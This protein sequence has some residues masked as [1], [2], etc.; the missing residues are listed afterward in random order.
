M[1]APHWQEQGKGPVGAT[2]RSR[3]KG[4]RSSWYPPEQILRMPW[5]GRCEDTFPA[6][7]K[8]GD[9]HSTVQAATDLG[10]VGTSEI[11]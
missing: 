11:D 4:S 6:A 1:A 10:L 3:R 9:W 2:G 8:L 5:P 7:G